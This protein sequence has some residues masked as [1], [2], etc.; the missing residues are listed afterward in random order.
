MLAGLRRWLRRKQYQFEV[1]F[2]IYM[3]TAWE[4]FA[5][6]SV[7]FL[8]CGLAFI[9]AILY[10]PHHVSSLA[11]RAWYYI[12]GEDGDAA[13]ARALVRDVSAAVQ[14]PSAA[15]VRLREAIGSL[16]KEL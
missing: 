11:G 4:K 3:H 2:G 5:I 7:L 16:D 14:R 15:A 10:L 6:Y 8:L 9:A 13:E 1:T 12:R